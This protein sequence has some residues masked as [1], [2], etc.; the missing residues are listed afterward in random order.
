MLKVQ[1]TFTFTPF[2]KV[3][4][5]LDRYHEIRNCSTTLSGDLYRMLPKSVKNYYKYGNKSGTAVAQ[6]LR[7]CATDRK[8]VGSIPSGVIGIFH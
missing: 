7:C 4:L 1:K 2:S 6:W 3:R 5:S 8:V